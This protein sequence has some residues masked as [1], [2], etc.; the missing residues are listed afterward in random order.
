MVPTCPICGHE[1]CVQCHGDGSSSVKKTLSVGARV[2]LVTYRD[3]LAAIELAG[4]SEE[5]VR[6]SKGTVR[7]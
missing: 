3:R 4:G 5:R 2:G 1:H 6:C 7:Q